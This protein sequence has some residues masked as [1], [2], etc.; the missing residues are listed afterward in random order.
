MFSNM[1]RRV[2]TQTFIRTRNNNG[3]INSIRNLYW[4]RKDGDFKY[5]GLESSTIDIYEGIN[6]IKFPKENMI[7][8]GE[9]LFEV[10]TNTFLDGIFES[11]ENTYVVSKN[12]NIMK[13]INFNPEEEDSWIIKIRDVD[14]ESKSY[15]K[16][17]RENPNASKEEKRDAIK[18]FYT[19]SF[20]PYTYSSSPN[21][22][23]KDKD[24]KKYKTNTENTPYYPHTNVNE[25]DLIYYILSNH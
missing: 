16:F 5:I 6:N 18:K 15:G 11:K 14:E 24:K 23:R 19:T 25:S 20:T 7:L 17:L 2:F 8:K 22:Y 4:T 9:P 3:N 21:D 10:E 12:A 13:T 1:A